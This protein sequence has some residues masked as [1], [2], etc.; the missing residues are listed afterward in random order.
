MFVRNKHSSLL[1]K[2]VQCLPRTNALAY[3]YY[4]R[5]EEKKSFTKFSTAGVQP[6]H[7]VEKDRKTSHYFVPQIHF[8]AIK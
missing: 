2:S 1:Q 7:F 5:D 3:F 6:N 4:S 8:K